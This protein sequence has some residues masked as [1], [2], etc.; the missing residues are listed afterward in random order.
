M[1]FAELL[2]QIGFLSR[3]AAHFPVPGSNRGYT[4]SAVVP[5]WILMWHDGVRGLEDV[6]HIRQDKALRKL[7]GLR[8]VPSADLLGDWLRRLGKHGVGIKAWV[9][10]NRWVLG[11]TLGGCRQVTLDSDATPVLAEQRSA[12]WMDLTRQG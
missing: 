9:E 5:L 1:C 11:L 4:P 7:L 2:R 8:R 3:V 10:V 12:Q 6:R